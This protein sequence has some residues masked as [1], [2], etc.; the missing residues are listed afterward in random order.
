MAKIAKKVHLV[1]RSQFR[2]DQILIDKLSL[3]DNIEI[4][5][6]TTIQRINGNTLVESISVKNHQTGELNT[7]ETNGI[8]VEIGY[9]PNSDPFENLIEL[10][11][12]KE[13]IIDERGRTNIP[14]IFAAGDV[15]T[16][17]YKQIVIA[18]AEGAKATLAAND[19][20]NAL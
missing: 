15:T 2:A 20:L 17:P 14:G 12:R 18:S 6:E 8:I 3:L 10:S 1:H 16:V 4:H 19:Y 7:I 13:I 9:L 11:E 5:L